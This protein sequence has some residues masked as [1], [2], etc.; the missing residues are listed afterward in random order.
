M[1]SIVV[2]VYNAEK[3]IQTTIEMVKKQT[4]ED[5]ELILV[6]DCSKDRS[7]DVIKSC[8]S[9]MEEK[10]R[11]VDKLQNEGAAKARNTGIEQARGRYIAFLDADDIWDKRKLEVQMAFMKKH[12]AAFVFSAYEFGDENGIPTGK[13]VRV[14]KTL[15]YK[16]ALSRTVI[17]TSTV[18]LDTEK[19][20]KK[21]IYMPDIGS[22]DTATWWQILK[23]GITA[24]GLNEPLAIYRRPTSSLSSDK[25]KAIKRIWNLYKMVAG[26]N[27]FISF[28]YMLSWAIRATTRRVVDDTIRAHAE[29]IKRFAVIE[30]AVIG[31]LLQTGLFAYMWFTRFYPLISSFRFSQEG[32]EFGAGLKLYF[33]GHLLVI[34]IYL[35]ILFFIT[36][37]SGGM[38]TGYLK[39]GNIFTS[40]SVALVFTNIIMYFQMSLMR[41]WLLPVNYMLVLTVGQ[42][43]FAGTWA[44]ISDWI[45]KKVFPP[46]ETLVIQGKESLGIVMRAFETRED[47]FKIM[48][49]IKVEDNIDEVKDE[50]L[51]WYGAVI[52]GTMEETIRK[53]L[54]EFCYSHHIRVYF[55]PDI[56]DILI[57]SA[58]SMDLFDIPILE[59]K[60]YSISWENRLIKRVIDL[61]LACSL[62]LIT[63]P[64]LLI[65][66]LWTK[67][68]YG[69]AF[70]IEE[71]VGK[72]QKKFICH[73]L[74][75]PNYE[76][77]WISS[78]PM[79]WDVLQGKMSIV[80]PAPYTVEQ[81]E[82]LCRLDKRYRYRLRVL[83]GITGIA[84][85]YG[86][87]N[88]RQEDLLKL[89]IM[90][91]QQYSILMDMRLFMLSMTRKNEL[92]NK[93]TA[94]YLRS[95]K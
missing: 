70:V 9:G 58:E 35:V 53:E 30:I 78:L 79:L 95:K 44:C 4:Y 74:N 26:M 69:K 17:F 71:C 92:T 89:D 91:V 68:T 75:L 27:S 12:D 67:V 10:I 11:L 52:M 6:N 56:S 3:Y 76:D 15:T 50:C 81:M 32:I 38:R 54:V 7:V 28:F 25:G 23:S 62:L 13:A 63:S 57:K 48:R 55:L 37:V 94:R 77:G 8:M 66:S 88:T 42:I 59:I 41:N 60:E 87:K 21:L 1:I 65:V 29:A 83:P 39:A 43:V 20:D 72:G 5:W 22:E 80:G 61:I 36:R 82:E 19:I 86:E 45:Y 31:L 46:V 47:R 49:V 18:L 85:L 2:P 51:R 64:V 33:R 14:P 84:Q 34:V 73:R 40:Q 16:K 93:N 90:Y 24:Y